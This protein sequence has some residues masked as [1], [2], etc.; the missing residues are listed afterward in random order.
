MAAAGEFKL[1]MTNGSTLS[2]YGA[3]AAAIGAVIPAMFSGV[4]AAGTTVT[5]WS[6]ASDCYIKDI[7]VTSP[8]TG[9]IDFYNV[10]RGR[11]ADKIVDLAS[12]YTTNTVRS[13]PPIGFKAGNVYRIVVS[14]TFIT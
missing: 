6:P 9:S 1:I 10:T 14:G 13:P 8:A 7:L 11:R 3:S 5:D 4:A 12:F 2:C